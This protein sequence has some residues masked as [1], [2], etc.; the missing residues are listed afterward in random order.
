MRDVG[1]GE[2]EEEEKRSKTYSYPG[3]ADF[4]VSPPGGPSNCGE[5]RYGRPLVLSTE[6]SYDQGNEQKL[7]CQAG[8]KSDLA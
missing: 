6:L 7:R 1:G 8:L 5:R 2:K 3:S 4:G